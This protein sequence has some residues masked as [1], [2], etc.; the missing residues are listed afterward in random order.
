M[1]DTQKVEILV[2]M[3]KVELVKVKLNSGKLTMSK[4]TNKT[5][6]KSFKQLFSL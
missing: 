4:L 1:E 2:S 5:F 3:E 6:K